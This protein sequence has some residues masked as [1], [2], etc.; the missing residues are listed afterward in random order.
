MQA[1]LT[2]ILLLDDEDTWPT[3]I[4]VYRYTSTLAGTHA[5]VDKCVFNATP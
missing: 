5:H 3:F 1:V 4:K 2:A